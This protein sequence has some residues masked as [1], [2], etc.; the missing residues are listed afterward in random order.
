M[1]SRVIQPMELLKLLADV[2]A[3]HHEQFEQLQ[4]NE[5]VRISTTALRA[6]RRRG[7]LHNMIDYAWV[8]TDSGRWKAA[9]PKSQIPNHK[10]DDHD[11]AGS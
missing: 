2:G 9:N 5:H 4:K 11:R 3:V 8:L 10:S 7:W 6:L 1:K